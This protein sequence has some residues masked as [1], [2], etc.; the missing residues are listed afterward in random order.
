MD[1]RCNTER[2]EHVAHLIVGRRSREIVEPHVAR[3]QVLAP[4]VADDRA[5]TARHTG[6]CPAARAIQSTAAVWR[7]ASCRRSSR[8]SVTPKVVTRRRMSVRRPAAIISLPV[9]TSE[10]K[11]SSSGSASSAADEVRRDARQLRRRI[12]PAPPRP[13]RASPRGDRAPPRAALDTARARHPT[14]ARSSS[15]A[16]DADSDSS[17]RSATMSFR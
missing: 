4:A 14:R 8:A 11:H 3:R 6:P 7:S 5:P 15:L 1:A 2:V 12:P 17:L 10:R 9:A 13:D 16:C